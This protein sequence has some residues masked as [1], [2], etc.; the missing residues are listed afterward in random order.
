MGVPSRPKAGQKNITVKCKGIN[1]MTN[2][3][4]V[5]KVVKELT[6]GEQLKLFEDDI[7]DTE[8]VE[9]KDI[10]DTEEVESKD[11]PEMKTVKDEDLI[12]LSFLDI[13]YAVDKAVKQ[14]MVGPNRLTRS[15]LKKRIKGNINKR[16]KKKG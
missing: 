16:V 6:E 13:E 1:K 10:P 4:A 3:D 15:M 11:P 2:D 7:P 12:S 9:S 8:K 14:T 5:K